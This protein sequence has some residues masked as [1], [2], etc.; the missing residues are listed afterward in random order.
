VKLLANHQNTAPFIS[1]Q[2]IQRFVTSNPSP[3]YVER[4][5]RVFQ[6]NK[7]NL[8]L[9]LRAVLLA[10]EARDLT[11]T[12]ESSFGKV[13]EPVL[14][15]SA[16]F[17][18]MDAQSASGYYLLGPTNEAA[19][20]LNQSPLFAP[21]VFNFYR[22]GYVP[23]PLPAGTGTGTGAGAKGLI[24]PEVQIAHETSMAGYVNFSRNVISNG[25][26]E[27]GLSGKDENPDIQFP[28]NLSN[29]N[30]LLLLA[31]QP[32][33]LIKALN[34]KLVNGRLS[35]QTQQEISRAISAID[36]RTP[37]NA[38]Q[39][40]LDGTRLVRVRSAL[41]LIMASPEFLIQK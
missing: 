30:P 29:T 17:R 28:F 14:R 5:A 27:Y 16:L 38:T 15:L 32:T 7:G 23:P 22:P 10:P 33:Q 40:Q 25:A 37:T 8:G 6:A 36:Y 41:L 18:A 20:A 19:T 1:K 31:D 12:T 24:A 21:N 35:S 39:D 3:A 2:L 34:L 9:T 11:Q 26:G 4:V 13:R